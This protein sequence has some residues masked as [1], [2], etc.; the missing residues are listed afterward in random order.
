MLFKINSGKLYIALLKIQMQI[1][2][3]KHQ[4][5]NINSRWIRQWTKFCGWP[6]AAVSLTRS[7]NKLISFPPYFFFFKISTDIILVWDRKVCWLSTSYGHLGP[8]RL[9]LYHYWLNKGLE[10]KLFRQ[11]LSFKQ[12]LNENCKSTLDT[13]TGINYF[14]DVFSSA[15]KC[16]YQIK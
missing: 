5:N 2:Y 13:M 7:Y 16:K 3:K 6:S 12:E 15:V 14:E 8:Q 4:S 10:I 9:Y 11:L 1:D